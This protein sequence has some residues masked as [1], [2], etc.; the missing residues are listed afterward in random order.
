M[1]PLTKEIERDR[2]I[3]RKSSMKSESTSEIGL[4]N[5]EIPHENQER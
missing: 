5:Q 2:D 4:K 3:E 1:G